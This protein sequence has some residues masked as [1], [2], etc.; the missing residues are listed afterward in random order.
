MH[1]SSAGNPFCIRDQPQNLEKIHLSPYDRICSLLSAVQQLV[2]K[3]RLGVLAEKTV[4]E[5]YCAQSQN[6]SEK[7]K[8]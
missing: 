6:Q 8:G 1:G 5:E 3:S 4:Y 2:D 7:Y